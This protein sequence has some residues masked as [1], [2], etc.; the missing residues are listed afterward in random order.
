MT[1]PSLGAVA[2]LP[3]AVLLVAGCRSPEA[4]KQAFFES[5]TRYLAEGR[6]REAI[7]EYQNAIQTDPRFG[8]A[9]L[10]LAEVYM[11]DD[12]PVRA[13]SESVRAADLLPDDRRA[14]LQA[15]RLLLLSGQFDDAKTR[16][17]RLLATNPRDVDAHIIVGKALAGVRDRRRYRA[18]PGGG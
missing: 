13:L 10:K 15:G 3:F 14:Q 7:A 5:G 9:R 16:A 12:Q 17:V 4:T 1:F 8:E 2:M 6:I 18:G 11:L